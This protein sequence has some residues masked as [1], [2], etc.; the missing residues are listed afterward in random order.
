LK[1]EESLPDKGPKNQ[2]EENPEEGRTKMKNNKTNRMNKS[3]SLS[4]S[5]LM[6]EYIHKNI[7]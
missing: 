2:E 1:S 5:I 4:N 6:K 3:D 7:S